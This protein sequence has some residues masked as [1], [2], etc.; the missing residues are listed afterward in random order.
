MLFGCVSVTAL[1]STLAAPKQNKSCT[2]TPLIPSCTMIFFGRMFHLILGQQTLLHEDGS[3]CIYLRE[4]VC[5]VG[6]PEVVYLE[7][8][9]GPGDLAEHVV[10][11]G[12]QHPE[13]AQ[14]GRGAPALVLHLQTDGL[15]SESMGGLNIPRKRILKN[16]LEVVRN[17]SKC[18]L[19]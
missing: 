16:T 2:S 10:E 7:A 9:D 14:Q 17:C 18:L 6:V 8:D 4:G 15:K 3:L 12:G 5:P 19:K 1:R 13:G 11:E